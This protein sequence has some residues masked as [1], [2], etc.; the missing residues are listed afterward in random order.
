L[1]EAEVPN[2]QGRLRPGAFVR[3]ELITIAAEPAVFIPASALV[4]FAGIEKVFTV[5][6]G[7]AVE[8]L[9]RTGRKATDR[10][11]ISQGLKPGEQVIVRPGNL[12]TGQ[13]VVVEQGKG[14]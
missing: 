12:A 5:E 13:S 9:V 4:T 11:E 10:V 2:E 6:N 7:R 8:K 14:L 1:I 3:A